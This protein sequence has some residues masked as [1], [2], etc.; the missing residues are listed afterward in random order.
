[1]HSARAFVGWYNGLPAQREV[2]YLALLQYL[3]SCVPIEA[4][5]VLVGAIH[6]IVGKSL[7]MALIIFSQARKF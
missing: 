6:S 2:C 3:L 7:L 1:M 5:V 4:E